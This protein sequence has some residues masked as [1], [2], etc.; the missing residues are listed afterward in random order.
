MSLPHLVSGHRQSCPSSHLD[1]LSSLTVYLSNESIVTATEQLIVPRILTLGNSNTGER[2]RMLGSPFYSHL[3]HPGFQSSCEKSDILWG[4]QDGSVGKGACCQASK[5]WNKRA[6]TKKKYFIR[7]GAGVQFRGRTPA[8]HGL[9]KSIVTASLLKMDEDSFS[10]DFQYVP[11]ALSTSQALWGHAKRCH[12]FALRSQHL[13]YVC[14]HA[15]C[16]SC[17]LLIQFQ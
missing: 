16:V 7:L 13:S 3:S 15:L 8:W 1:I 4:H 12:C 2:R 14:D 5:R 10:G 9:T 11:P 17:C 6:R